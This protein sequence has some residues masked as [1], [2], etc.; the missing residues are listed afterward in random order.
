MGE[1]ET[2]P[3]TVMSPL[4][5]DPQAVPI[6]PAA[7]VMILRDGP[8]GL[9]VFMQQRNHG[10]QFVAGLHVFPGGG[11]DPQDGDPA[12]IE[13]CAGRSDQDASHR[14]GEETG[15]LAYW[16]A[17][18]RETFEEAGLL[19]AYREDGSPVRLDEPDMARR[20]AQH[21]VEVDQGRRTLLEVC[22][23]EQL[24]LAT[25]TMHYHSRWITPLGPKRRYDT[26]FFVA[27]APADQVASNDAREA[28]ADLWTSPVEALER[29]AAGD[30]GMITPTLLSLTDLAEHATVASVLDATAPYRDVP[31]ILPKR[32]VDES[33]ER[34]VLPGEPGY[35]T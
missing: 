4:S 3:R 21:R 26:R 30:L 16:A 35:D 14:V 32:I 6:L 1:H 7:T 2:I 11:V 12:M 28:I 22:E 25:D 18:I 19:L 31:A 20:F 33:G 10:S 13:R 34:V 9:E 27:P 23:A 29:Y 24:R 17:S 15:G 5:D 8:S